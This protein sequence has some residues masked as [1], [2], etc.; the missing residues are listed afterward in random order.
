VHGK[1]LYL[2]ASG[3]CTSQEAFLLSP[4]IDLTN[5]A[6][7]L[8]SFWAHMQGSSMGSIHV[9]IFDGTA[10]QLD[11]MTPLIGDQG[12]DWLEVNVDLSG[13]AGFG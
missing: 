6:G 11:V 1:Y 4:C 5:I 10:W 2:E 7:P 8:L 12:P 9:D 3:G 13:Y